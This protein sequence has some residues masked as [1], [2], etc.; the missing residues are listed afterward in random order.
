M[1][2]LA[3]CPVGQQKEPASEALSY[4]AL[5]PKLGLL[6][7]R[8]VKAGQLFMDGGNVRMR[9]VGGCLTF[10]RGTGAVIFDIVGRHGR[11]ST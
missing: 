3:T 2:I 10:L 1:A 11:G 6:C 5:E 4:L 7:Q 9:S 8:L